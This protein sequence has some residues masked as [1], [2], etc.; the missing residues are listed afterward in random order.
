M[1]T[2]QATYMT[3]LKGEV[4]NDKISRE[5]KILVPKSNN[6]FCHLEVNIRR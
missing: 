2:Q 6:S 5:N 4:K 3:A 1:L